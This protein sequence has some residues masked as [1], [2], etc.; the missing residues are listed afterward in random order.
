MTWTRLLWESRPSEPFD[1]I[2][3]WRMRVFVLAAV[4]VACARTLLA[5]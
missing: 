5:A 3:M 1:E 2:F 4:Q